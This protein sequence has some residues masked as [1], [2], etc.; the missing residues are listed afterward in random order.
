T[1]APNGDII[2]AE[3]QAYRVDRI[4]SQT[5]QISVVAGIQAAVIRGPNGIVIEPPVSFADGPIAVARF[6]SPYSVAA[7]PDGTTFYVA[8]TGNHRI[9]KI[10]TALG[11]VTTIA[12]T[13]VEG[14]LGDGNAAVLAE[15]S[16]PSSIRIGPEGSIL[17]MDFGNQRVRRI[18][19]NGNIDTIAGSG[20]ELITPTA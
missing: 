8:D 4:D 1:F 6:L 12:G 13:G 15:L 5:G 17:F 10:D 7:A 14:F 3:R 2:V 11:L 9:R 16:L 18:D 20:P 19:S